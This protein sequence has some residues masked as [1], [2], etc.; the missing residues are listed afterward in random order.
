MR[1]VERSTSVTIQASGSLLDEVAD[2][3]MGAAATASA[4]DTFGYFGTM[5]SAH[6][7]RRNPVDQQVGRAF[8]LLIRE[9]A[10]NNTTEAIAILRSRVGRH[11]A[12]GLG[13]SQERRCTNPVAEQ[14][15]GAAKWY[16]SMPD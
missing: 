14:V 11:L 13:K 2:A 12:D 10:V 3:I 15:R 16:R 5:Q 8:V 4:E 9:G 6:G 1:T 7:R